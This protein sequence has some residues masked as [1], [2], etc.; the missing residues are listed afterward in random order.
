MCIGYPDHDPGIRPRIAP[1][2]IYHEN[3]YDSAKYEQVIEA[4]DRVTRDYYLERTKGK[5]DTTWS[6]EMAAK[7]KTASRTHM[8]AFLEEQGFRFD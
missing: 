4:Y 2:A 1:E 5:R 3:S 7:F 6:E 8:R